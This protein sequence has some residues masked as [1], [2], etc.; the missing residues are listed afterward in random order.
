MAVS[1][2]WIIMIDMI[3]HVGLWHA[4]IPAMYMKSLCV[5]DVPEKVWK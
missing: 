2:L 4:C 3:C 1:W 5:F